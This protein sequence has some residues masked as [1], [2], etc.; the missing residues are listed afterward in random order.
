MLAQQGA[1][2]GRAKNAR[3]LAWSLLRHEVAVCT[4]ERQQDV[5]IQS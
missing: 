2:H 4:T 5:T 1:E 3:W